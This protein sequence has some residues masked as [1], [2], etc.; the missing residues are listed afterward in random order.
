MLE[1]P[2][3]YHILQLGEGPEPG[4]QIV[5]IDDHFNFEPY[6][7][8]QYNL[9]FC[10]TFPEGTDFTTIT[11]E[12][13]D[14]TATVTSGATSINL[15]ASSVSGT[16]CILLT[17]IDA[18]SVPSDG[19][20]CTFTL[21]V[22]G[23]DLYSGTSTC[24]VVEFKYFTIENMTALTNT[25]TFTKNG[26]PL[27]GADLS[28]STDGENFT[29]IS[30][31]GTQGTVAIDPHESIQLR[32]TSGLS[33]SSTNYYN[34]Q[35]SDGIKLSG[36]ARTLIDYTNPALDTAQ[37]YCFY[38]LFKGN[39]VYMM[40][41][42]DFSG[43]ENLADSC[44]M[45]MFE[46]C[47]GLTM[48]SYLPAM[49]LA[50]R[51]YKNM[52]KGCTNLTIIPS[53][54]P[55]TTLTADCYAYMFD[56]CSSLTTVPV[57]PATTL[58][59]SCYLAMF[60]NCS[61]LTQ[62]PA[63]PA[64]ILKFNVYA[65]MFE[66]CTSLLQAPELPALTL[67]DSSYYRMFRGCSSLNYSPTLPA[68]TAIHNSYSGMFNG[69]SSLVEA[70]ELMVTTLHHND[71]AQGMFSNCILLNKVIVHVPTWSETQFSNWLNNV[72]PT[73][74]FYNLGGAT[75]PTGASGIPVGWTEHTS[76]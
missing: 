71:P 24:L 65:N 3:L 27:T 4:P 12:H 25:I 13:P 6:G 39:T 29:P 61:S 56:G 8:N 68:T 62:A 31:T 76:L 9:E 52:Y 60:R 64:T 50:V 15:D 20:D 7:P 53:V 42:I 28:Y 23:E 55:A 54:L 2:I 69:C 57:L 21:S 49:T 66:N 35:A 48:T 41:A 10:V 37:N 36:D 75:I 47:T 38:S 70:P 1:I 59:S 63:L 26:T 17:G 72:S 19:S 11:A 22:D 51:C 40:S 30:Y 58:T 46:N 33:E 34:I 45:S 16:D 14:W 5:T 32:S 74:D 18:S 44:Y 73:G 67:T 43:L